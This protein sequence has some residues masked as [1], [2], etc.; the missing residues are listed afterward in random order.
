MITEEMNSK[1]VKT[2]PILTDSP[3]ETES[4]PATEQTAGPVAEQVSMS[5]SQLKFFPF[6]TALSEKLVKRHR[7]NLRCIKG[8]SDLTLSGN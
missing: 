1:K 2:A 5:D 6:D 3:N 4:E 7:A 8:S